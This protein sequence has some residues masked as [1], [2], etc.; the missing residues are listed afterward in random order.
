MPLTPALISGSVPSSLPLFFENMG[1]LEQS[2]SSVLLRRPN[3]VR[4]AF[5]PV[6]L[7]QQLE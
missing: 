6:P 3:Y 2:T 4:K 7:A 1:V 5:L